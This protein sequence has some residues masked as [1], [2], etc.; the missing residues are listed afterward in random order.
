VS[1]AVLFIKAMLAGFVVAVPIGAIGAMCLRRALQG[2][3]VIGLLSG[4]GSAIADMALAMAAMFGLSLLTHY[5]LE[6]HRPVL[7]VG[8]AFLVFIGLRMIHKRH[9]NLNADVP[10]LNDQLRRWR[11]WGAALTTGFALTIIN[12]ATLIAFMG[13]FAGLGLVPDAPH[14]LLQSWLII[15]GVF[16]GSMLWWM[17]LTGTA[18][19]IRRH[20][21]LDLVAILNVIL[22]VLVVGFGVASLLS[23]LGYEF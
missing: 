23:S 7:F 5:I 3:W 12:P 1:S 21:P 14:R 15:A 18:F 9:P 2:R 19:A 16:A 8:G 6:N 20:L 17:T 4:T 13:V 11:V 10:T 22:G